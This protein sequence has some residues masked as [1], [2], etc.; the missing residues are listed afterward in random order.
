MIDLGKLE[1]LWRMAK[2]KH[3]L[4]LSSSLL[5]GS[6]NSLPKEGEQENEEEEKK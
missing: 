6:A 5:P 2:Q 4:S 3:A 1:N